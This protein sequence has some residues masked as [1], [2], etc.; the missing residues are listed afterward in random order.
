MIATL[1]NEA[2]LGAV[3]TDGVHEQGEGL[4]LRNGGTAGVAGPRIN[5]IHGLFDALA[6]FLTQI[7][8][9]KPHLGDFT[10]TC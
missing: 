7:V 9:L 3:L 10:S 4:D 6:C 1:R 8:C 5:I 2:Y